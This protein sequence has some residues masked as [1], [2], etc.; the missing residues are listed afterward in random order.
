M[1]SHE[2][3]FHLFH[4]FLRTVKKQSHRVSQ[5]AVFAACSALAL[6]KY[7]SLLRD[8]DFVPALGQKD[9]L[10]VATVACGLCAGCRVAFAAVVVSAVR[11]YYQAVA[12]TPNSEY[13]LYDEGTLTRASSSRS[14]RLSP[15]NP[16]QSH[17]REAV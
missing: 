10:A 16:N 14:Y 3:I 7:T 9:V 17:S 5:A 12:K 2:K 8:A 15:K 11:K 4:Y 6:K 1:E 13:S